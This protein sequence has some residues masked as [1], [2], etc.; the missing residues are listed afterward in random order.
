MSA[1]DT[2]SENGRPR[3]LICYA[4]R[5]GSAKD[6]AEGL[7]EGMADADVDVLDVTEVGSLDYDLV[8][9]GS[10]IRFGSI[11]PAMAAFVEENREG[12]A[13]IPKAVFVVCFLTIFARSYLKRIKDLLEGDILAYRVFVGRAGPFSFVNLPYAKDAGAMIRSLV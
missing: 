11:H 3:I 2:S 1:A 7:A 4:T 5:G 9:L 13:S 6:V 8:V 12:L 10:S